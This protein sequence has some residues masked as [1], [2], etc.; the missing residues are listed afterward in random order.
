[1]SH[2]TEG[3]GNKANDTLNTF[4]CTACNPPHTPACLFDLEAD[5]AERNNLA[6]Q[7]PDV[8][9]SMSARLATLQATS[10]HPTFPPDDVP[11]ECAMLARTG[12]FVAPLDYRD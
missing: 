6:A 4:L 9:A 8:V 7:H 1:M 10:Y 3:K 11:A 5:P 2:I 12:G